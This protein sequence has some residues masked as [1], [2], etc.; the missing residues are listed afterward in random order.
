MS[1]VVAF[2]RFWWDFVVGD[3][4][5]TAVMVV[6]AI[7]ATALAARGDVSAWW[8]MPAAVA[9]VLYLSLRRATGR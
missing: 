3:D 5:R 9:G 7:G 4:W 2:A 8:V 6:A 1:Y